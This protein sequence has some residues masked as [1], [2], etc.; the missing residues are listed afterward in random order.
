[1]RNTKFPLPK[2]YWACVILC[3]ALG[4]LLFAKTF[5]FWPARLEK[6]SF[7]T[8]RSRIGA[9]LFLL[10]QVLLTA[11]MFFLA[12]KAGKLLNKR[13]KQVRQSF[14]QIKYAGITPGDFDYVWFDFSGDERAKIVTSGDAYYLYVESFDS[15]TESWNP[16]NTVSVFPT[17]AEIKK[18]LFYEF[19]FFCEEN[20]V[21]DFD[22]DEMFRDTH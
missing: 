18:S 3:L 5:L 2:K 6:E 1:M 15:K 12:K 11:L 9:I 20:T 4:I 7:A 16:V 10:T 19:D 8:L 14:D 21:L 22:G 17:L 13:D